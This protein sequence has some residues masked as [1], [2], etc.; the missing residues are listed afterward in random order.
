MSQIDHI[1]SQFHALIDQADDEVVLAHFYDA[2]A[3]SIQGQDN[4]LWQLS[5][6]QRASMQQAY[7]ESKQSDK[8]ITNADVWKKYGQWLTK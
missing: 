5:E 1:K 7:E 2:L 8:L 3:A 6:Q 4:S